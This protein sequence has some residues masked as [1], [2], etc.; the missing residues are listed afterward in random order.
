MRNNK[1]FFLLPSIADI[2]F[3]IIFFYLSF[4]AGEGLLADCDTGYHIRAGEFILNTHSIPRHDIFSFTAPP[5]PWIAHEWLSELVMALIHKKFGLTGIVIFFSFII[6]LTYYV[7]FKIIK[8][9]RRNIILAASLIAL[10][11]GTSQLHWLARPHIFSLFLTVIWYYLLDAYQYDDKNYL[12]FLPPIM[13]LWVNL[14]G[15]FMAGFILIG[16]YLLGN[17]VQFL[18]SEGVDNKRWR[19]KTKLLGLT[20]FVCLI[21]SL[22]NP[23]GYHMLL[24]PFKL[25][26]NK[27]IMGSVMEFLSPNFHESMPFTYLLFLMITI[28]AISR[29]SLN[30][31]EFVLIILFTYMALYSVRYIPL[32]AVISAPILLRQADIILEKMGGRFSEFLKNKSKSIAAM[33]ASSKGHLWPVTAVLV[34]IIF[35]T[36][37]RIEYQFDKKVKPVDAVEFLKKENLTGNMF[38]NGEFGDYIIYS[39]WPQYKVF[40]D[41]RADVYGEERMKDYFKLARIE[42]GWDRVLSK[43]N[44]NWVIDNANS[45]LSYFFL[46]RRDW[47]LIYADKVANI[48]VNN[49]PQNQS[50]IRKYPNIR[51]VFDEDKDGTK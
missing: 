43:Y 11:I 23:Y 15:G 32:F 51:L 48:F 16:V 34:V 41:G 26:S 5:L 8:T 21:V 37:G 1:I 3:L 47:K 28:F 10:V 27:F 33:D 25:M 50:L 20:L 19:R 14:H 18:L 31:I 45:T 38:T 40:F 4:S 7:L 17:F 24:F 36:Y 13:L 49:T 46:E 29:V 42:T 2:L 35:V 44:I 30:I 22:I 6:A 12:Y 9:Y 39:A